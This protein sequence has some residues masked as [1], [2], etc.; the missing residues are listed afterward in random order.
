MPKKRQEAGTGQKAKSEKKTSGKKPSSLAKKNSG[1]KGPEKQRIPVVGMGAS[2]GGLQALEAFFDNM[3]EDA[4][5]AFVVVTH[6]DPTHASMMPELVQRHTKMKV[7]QVKD[8]M[9]IAP[10]HVYVIP[11]DRDMGIVNRTLTLAKTGI[12]GAPRAPVNYFL[13]SLAKELKERAVAVIL[14]GMGTDGTEGVKAMK[15]ELGMV[16]AQEPASAK[17]D[18]MPKYA[19]ATGLADFVLP[20]EKMPR[21]LIDYLKRFVIKPRAMVSRPMEFP[22]KHLQKI[23]MLIR[24]HTGQDFSNYKQTTILRRIQRRMSLHQIEAIGEYLGYLQKNSKEVESLFKEL[25]IGVTSFFRDSEAFESLRNN[26]LPLL[27]EKRETDLPLRVWV[28]GCATGEEAYSLAVIIREF[29]E[30]LERVYHVQIFA[31][32]IDTDALEK[33]R[34]GLFP[35]NIA[36]DVGTERLEKFFECVDDSYQVGR[37]IREM[38][39]FAVQSVIKD[40]PFTKLDLICCRNLLIYLQPDMQKRLLPLFHYSL[41]PGGI[42]FLGS[43]E[44]VGEF[45]DLFSPVDNKWKIYK[46][47]SEG[48][49]L[50][51]PIDFPLSPSLL[52]PLGPIKPGPRS[53][54]PALVEK[55]LMEHHTPPTAVIDQKGEIAYIHGRT[56]RYL[57]TPPG[58]ARPANIIEMARNA[59]R[60]HLPALVR[61]AASEKKEDSRTVKMTSDGRDFSVRLTVK[62]VVHKDLKELYM[63][64]FEELPAEEKEKNTGKRQVRKKTD[65]SRRVQQLEEE[66]RSTKESLQTTIEELETSNEELR[67]VNEE[68]QSA[69][70]ELQSAN[71]ELNSSKEEMQSLNE[72]LETVNAELQGKNQE[73]MKANDDMKNLLDSLALPTIFL[74]N[75][76]RIKRF[77]AQADKVVNLRD[78][79][80]GRPLGDLVLRIKYDHLLQDAKEVLKSL[81]PREMEIEGIDGRWYSVRIKPYR[82]V[83]NFIDG[84]VILFVNIHKRKAAEEALKESAALRRFAENIVNTVRE[85][86]VVLDQ[87]FR[88]AS[89]NNS[90]Y[91]AFALKPEE[92]L[93]KTLY[94]LHDGAWDI[95]DL[96]KLLEQILPEKTAF[97]NYDME[98]VFPGL[99]VKKLQLNAR[100]MEQE[101]LGFDKILLAIEVVDDR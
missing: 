78:S 59:L 90:F 97:E 94:E 79:D 20:P 77:T 13:R 76:L 42:L 52:P 55:H 30:T 50:H 22:Q 18:S 91:G 57:E 40:P 65:S 56:G 89:A 3:P 39:I 99:G 61:T 4:N 75:S 9:T 25:L 2:A 11:P 70:E 72:E 64:L 38:L 36:A 98:H 7:L 37:R 15:A 17:Y 16:M 49:A 48:I 5:I 33:A 46:A 8:G 74:D 80:T 21:H 35:G 43:S 71:E 31:T 83:E 69:N 14:S 28:P 12:S 63:V 101:E 53:D 41:N 62:P 82:T 95:P 88:I 47:R 54:L 27:F 19:I 1:T 58:P 92:A 87:G 32:D 45:T 85:P 10:N 86:L 73:L 51:A 96:R 23:Y 100:M 68:Y 60:S 84:L 34:D 24:D 6:L 93:G 81:A 66:L 44:S 26:A 29:L 67:S